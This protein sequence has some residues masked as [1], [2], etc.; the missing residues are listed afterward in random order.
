MGQRKRTQLRARN[1]SFVNN[2]RQ[3]LQVAV[4]LA[5]SRTAVFTPA[6][7]A[8]IA[9]CGGGGGGADSSPTPTPTPQANVQIVSVSNSSPTALTPVAIK[10]SGLDVTRNFT[11]TLTQG[12]VS[13][14]ITPTRSA[15]DG[16][17]VIGVP[18]I[19]D[20]TTGLTSSGTVTVQISQD[21]ST[22]SAVTLAVQDLPSVASY[23]VAPGAISRAYFNYLTLS[24]ARSLNY[25]QA[26]QA[27]P[28]NTTD[29]SAVR[30]SIQQQIQDAIEMRSNVDLI[31]S[32][33]QTA[34]GVNT[35]NGS[36]VQ[37]DSHSVD[38]LD[39]IIA[40][41]LQAVG[42]LP[43]TS[44][45]TGP[46]TSVS[47]RATVN[48]GKL[49]DALSTSF[50]TAASTV[51][52][53]DKTSDTHTTTDRM[54]SAVGGLA[55]GVALGAGIFLAATTAAPIVTGAVVVGTLC[56]A[57]SCVR[58]WQ[59]I[60]QSQEGF[61]LNKD[62]AKFAVDVA[63]TVTGAFGVK[64]VGTGLVAAASAGLQDF[65]KGTAL[66]E[67]I[68]GTGFFANAGSLTLT[69]I[70]DGKKATTESQKGGQQF[71][72]VDGTA[73]VTNS[74]GP[75]LSG[76]SGVQLTDVT[77]RERFFTMAGIS[78]SYELVVP[79]GVQGVDYSKMNVQTFDPITGSTTGSPTVVDLR[80][81][82]PNAPVKIPTIQG[83]CI[84]TD[85]GSPDSDD[86]DCD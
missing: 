27:F 55:G 24:L 48:Y 69:L 1:G 7:S 78:G 58:D 40:M 70:G 52:A 23:G 26:I 66:A 57:Y 56:G 73:N 32:G 43:N 50:G 14:S 39:R 82:S 46:L 12:G 35:F 68:Q 63:G 11:V 6:M 41:H 51:D 76:L 5:L 49:I 28:S 67:V 77:Q 30:A 34:L 61:G 21:S 72:L 3:F 71:G 9:G 60:Q 2:R 64:A 22:S 20:K 54:I 8:I 18:L 16:T 84:D 33:K 75:I 10:T 25:L 62:T 29:T 53:I 59:N 83:Q 37:F 45:P 17:V 80:G 47:V 36:S 86:P 44:F 42:Y 38:V 19:F 4:S 81:V 13:S 74:Q 65:G 31:V 79:I 15:S 85:A